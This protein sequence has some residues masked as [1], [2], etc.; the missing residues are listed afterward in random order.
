MIFGNGFMSARRT[1]MEQLARNLSRTV[2]R[3]VVDKTGL[4]GFYD[5]DLRVPAGWADRSG[6]TGWPAVR[7]ARSR[8]TVNLHG[9]AGTAW[10]E[11]GIS[12]RPRRAA[13][14]RS[15]RAAHPGLENAEEGEDAEALRRGLSLRRGA[16]RDDGRTERGADG[17]DHLR[18]AAAPWRKRHGGRRRQGNRD[19]VRCR[20]HLSL[21]DLAEGV[22]TVRVEMLGFTPVSRELAL[23]SPDPV[24]FEMT[25]LPFD[26]IA[27]T[28][29]RAP[30]SSGTRGRSGEFQRTEVNA[31]RTPPRG[32]RAAGCAAAG[33][34]RRQ[35]D[36]RSRRPADQRQRE[37]RRRL[38]VRAVG[39]VRQ[40]PPRHAVALQLAARHAAR[41]LGV[42]CAPV[43][44]QRPADGRSRTTA[45]SSS[46]AP[47]A[48]RCGFPACS[49]TARRCSW[50]ISGSR[51]QR[52][53]PVGADADGAR[54]RRR[55]L[56]TRPIGRP[57][58]SR[59]PACRSPAT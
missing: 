28:A 56:A 53:H 13:R 8:C 30:A 18:D 37:Q 45:T 33:S 32:T 10:L 12:A 19:D 25:L 47:S 1:S 41:Q 48:V 36:E 5:A 55:F 21:P 26:E 7:R 38:A 27:R 46:W 59:Q 15:R 54:A 44:V 24:V 42:G 49:G 23:P 29:V 6:R 50:A 51:S 34:I 4:T 2:R 11:A 9:D 52:Q 16:R 31:A 40:Q 39:R 17:P 57:D 58:R 43:L 35:R 22:W 20:R 3:I 14:D